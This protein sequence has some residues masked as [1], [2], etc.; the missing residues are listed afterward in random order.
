MKNYKILIFHK[1]VSLFFVLLILLAPALESTV[2]IRMFGSVNKD[3]LVSAVALPTTPVPPTR[4]NLSTNTVT[5]ALSPTQFGY[6]ASIASRVVNNKS[7]FLLMSDQNSGATFDYQKQGSSFGNTEMMFALWT[8]YTKNNPNAN[9]VIYLGQ[10][11]T[12]GSPVDDN[13]AVGTLSSSNISFADLNGRAKSITIVSDFNDNVNSTAS[14]QNGKKLIFAV[15]NPVNNTVAQWF[16]GVPTILRNVNVGTNMSDTFLVPSWLKIYAQG[17]PFAFSNGAYIWNSNGAVVNAMVYGGSD[18][19][20]LITD[21]SVWIGSSG[22]V[23]NNFSVFGGNEKSGTIT[24]N[25]RVTIANTTG[26]DTFQTMSGG[27]LAGTIKG[28]TS[29][30]IKTN[31]TYIKRIFGGGVGLSTATDL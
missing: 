6:Q 17:S 12:I 8:I 31:N 11:T 24:G 29:L 16:L 20:D 30:N 15:F 9:Y 25:T 18:T 23:G 22:Q 1:I 5:D 21:T 4:P 3:E 14:N 26:T 19:R 28:N 10:D 7:D 13:G 2:L 27:S